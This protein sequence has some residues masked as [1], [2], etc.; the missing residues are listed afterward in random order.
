MQESTGGSYPVVSPTSSCL[1]GGAGGNWARRKEMGSQSGW[2]GWRGVGSRW[3][4]LGNNWVRRA[5]SQGSFIQEGIEKGG[6]VSGVAEGTQEQ[7]NSPK[8][9]GIS[10]FGLPAPHTQRGLQVVPSP[11]QTPAGS[12]ETF[13]GVLQSQPPKLS[14]LS[15]GLVAEQV[16]GLP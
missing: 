8:G 1:G 10:L 16:R 5:K 9:W 7:G 14:P 6:F 12:A 13:L 3:E 2:T 4:V 11:R 15:T